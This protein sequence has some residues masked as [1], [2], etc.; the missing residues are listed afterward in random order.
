MAFVGLLVIQRNLSEYLNVNDMLISVS[1]VL[2]FPNVNCA[3]IQE[4]E[5]E[6]N[7]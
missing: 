1:Y 7:M 2:V 3:C 6:N 4:P 5:M